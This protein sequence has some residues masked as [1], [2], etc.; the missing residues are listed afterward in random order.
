MINFKNYVRRVGVLGIET[1]LR[2][3]MNL[4]PKKNYISF[5][6]TRGFEGSPKYLYFSLKKKELRSQL[7]W[8]TADKAFYKLH[9]ND[10]NIKYAYSFSGIKIYA[11]S[12]IYVVSNS[13]KVFGKIFTIPRN[14]IVIQTGHGIPIKAKGWCA[15]RFYSDWDNRRQC[16][17]GYN[18]KNTYVVVSGKYEEEA[19]KTCYNV[20]DERFL[21][22]GQ[23]RNVIFKNTVAEREKLLKK[24]PTFFS[25]NK[26]ILYAPTWRGYREFTLFPF[27]DEDIEILNQHM[28]NNGY[29]LI[30]K[31]HPLESCDFSLLENLSNIIAYDKNWGLD[32]QEMQVVADMLIT[33]YSSIYCDYLNSNKPVA[34]MHYDIEEYIEKRGLMSYD[35]ELFAG[36]MINNYSQFVAECKKLLTD[37]NYYSN[38]RMAVNTIFNGYENFDSIEKLYEFFRTIL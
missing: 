36:P 8:I 16:K 21:R 13:V 2:W 23:P 9:K 12:S 27:E 18:N 10:P 33:D 3:S 34:F 22:I 30:V 6:A 19:L 5:S 28:K 32:N 15:S 31:M 38:E 11:Q 1:I 37:I 26:I 35:S 25:D 29:V 24:L 7:F 14:S 4:V 17:L 20:E